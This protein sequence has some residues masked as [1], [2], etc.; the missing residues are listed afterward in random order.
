[1]KVYAIPADKLLALNAGCPGLLDH[2]ALVVGAGHD[3][4][5]EILRDKTEGKSSRWSVRVSGP[6][7]N[8]TLDLDASNVAA[9]SVA[10]PVFI[11]D[12]IREI[13]RENAAILASG[14]RL[15]IEAVLP[16]LRSAT[17]KAPS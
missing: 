1:M 16:F 11:T 7:T 8:A 6:G 17:S 13:Q 12:L 10:I 4:V 9:M 14:M 2:V 3:P 5:I 15:G